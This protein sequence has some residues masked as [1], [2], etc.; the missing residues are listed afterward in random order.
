M[1]PVTAASSG[2]PTYAQGDPVPS[3]IPVQPAPFEVAMP[4]SRDT[5]PGTTRGASP[6]PTRKRPSSL[7]PGFS[8]TQ[9]FEMSPK[10]TSPQK[11]PATEQN[12]LLTQMAAMMAAMQNTISNLADQLTAL[13][14]KNEDKHK[15]KDKEMPFMNAEEV[16]K[17]VKFGSQIWS[18]WHVD[19][20]NFLRK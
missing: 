16:N 8:R 11:T 4:V 17:L 7:P 19:F 12:G 14:D 18:T 5:S 9:I 6:T 1:D 13:K 3:P 10:P 20:M 15:D 2:V